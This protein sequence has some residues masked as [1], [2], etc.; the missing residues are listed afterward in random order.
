MLCDA[1]PV[2][3]DVMGGTY[4]RKEVFVPV[5]HPHKVLALALLKEVLEGGR[6]LEE[7]EMRI[8]RGL[9]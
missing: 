9:E 7:G 8:K 4:C 3:C 5:V 6:G 1:V 2:L